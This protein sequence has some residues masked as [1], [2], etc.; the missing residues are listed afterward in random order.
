MER[1]DPHRVMVKKSH[2]S[3]SQFTAYDGQGRYELWRI[4]PPRRT[5]PS[6]NSP[7]S[8]RPRPAAALTALGAALIM[9]LGSAPRRAD[10]RSVPAR[11]GDDTVSAVGAI[12]RFADSL[13]GLSGKLFARFVSPAAQTPAVPV[14]AQL[15]G[16]SN[17]TR[18]GMYPLAPLARPFAFITL[19]PFAEKHG[20]SLGSYR[21]G[22]WPAEK[23]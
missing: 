19:H 3:H 7:M 9:S 20:L 21:L 13:R 14:F 17:L 15:F 10:A 23:R 1:N 18:P 6:H 16:D 11:I 22:F 5:R 2:L 4:P 8:N 12:V